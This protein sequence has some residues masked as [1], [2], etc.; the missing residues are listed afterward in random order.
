MCN[1]RAWG[2]RGDGLAL[3]LDADEWITLAGE[4]TFTGR[5]GKPLELTPKGRAVALA[6]HGLAQRRDAW[7]PCLRRVAAVA[8]VSHE[9]A[10]WWIGHLE[11]AG[12]LAV[13]DRKSPYRGRV[14]WRPLTLQLQ[15]P[16]GAPIPA[17]LV[18]MARLY[19]LVRQLGMPARQARNWVRVGLGRAIDLLRWIDQQLRRM[20][21]LT[22]DLLTRVGGLR[23]VGE[24]IRGSLAD[25][26]GARPLRTVQ[27]RFDIGGE[28]VRGLT[29]SVGSPGA[30]P[31]DNPRGDP[32]EGAGS[33]RRSDGE[34]ALRS[35]RSGRQ[36]RNLPRS[37][38]S[39]A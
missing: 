35:S 38:G 11:Q 29:L 21:R 27:D 28:S 24:I 39:R 18:R 19:H 8:G 33:G 36:R 15:I 22:G 12:L 30:R 14:E 3:C 31:V 7:R 2:P 6:L 17:H 26:V 9:L 13:D 25:L 10:R 20:T 37:R 4:S 16:E 32:E 34:R 23:H 5:T 1:G